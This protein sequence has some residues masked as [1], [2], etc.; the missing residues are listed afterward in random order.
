MRAFPNNVSLRQLRAFQEVARS[1][2]FAAAARQLHITQSALSESIR[3]LEEAVGVRLFDRTTRSVGL[4]A[5]GAEFLEDVQQSLAAL[6]LGLRRMDDLASLRG[7]EVRIAAAPSVL[8]AIVLPSLPALQRSHPGLRVQLFEEVASTIVRLVRE[9]Q[10]DFGISG[11]HPSV[12]G[13]EAQPLLCDYMGLLARADEPL[14]QGPAPQASQLA[15]RDCIGLTE[16]TAISEL[17]LSGDDLP[18]SVQ[19]PRLRVSHTLLLC[20]AIRLGLGV[21]VMPALTAKHPLLGDL[22]F[23]PL[24]APRIA[25]RIMLLQRPR[26]SLSPAAR[27][28]FDAIARQARAVAGHPG[29]VWDGE[30]AA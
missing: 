5:A 11:W 19:R 17:L 10:V 18:E 12:R 16:D 28:F 25:R 20:Q 3:Q 1:T 9:G 2:A 4:T 8:A 14:L 26:R 6:E 7:G 21:A 29:I 13:L 27:V 30:G 15:G 22:R 23:R 24:A